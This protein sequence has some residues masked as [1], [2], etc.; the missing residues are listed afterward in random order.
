MKTYSVYLSAPVPYEETRDVFDKETKKWTEQVVV[1]E[2]DS[3]TFHSLR[4]AKAFIK[5]HRDLY[6]SSSI[7][8]I[9]SN[10]DFENLGEI[11]LEGSNRTFVANTRQKKAGY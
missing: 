4:A 5:K 11:K 6:K 7:T 3:F 1:K 9:W 10:G 2:S 8:Q